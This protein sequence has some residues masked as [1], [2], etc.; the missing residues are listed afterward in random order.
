MFSTVPQSSRSLTAVM[1]TEVM[2][3]WPGMSVA[4]PNE[5]T[6]PS[7]VQ[8]GLA[9]SMTQSKPAGRGS[10]AVT[11]KAEPAPVFMIVMVKPIG[12]PATISVSSAAW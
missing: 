4:G 5:R 6:P 1:W 2:P 8:S 9:G 10:D 11:P 3:A 12:S 7:I